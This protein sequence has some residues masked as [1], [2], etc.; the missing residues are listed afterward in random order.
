MLCDVDFPLPL[1]F[2]PSESLSSIIF[3]CAPRQ[4][5]PLPESSEF[6]PHEYSCWTDKFQYKVPFRHDGKVPLR[7]WEELLQQQ[8]ESAFL[9]YL[10][11][12]V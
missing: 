2:C 10:I 6:P 8:R 11:L 3:Y 9:T 1:S 12:D 4:L 7:K 5:R